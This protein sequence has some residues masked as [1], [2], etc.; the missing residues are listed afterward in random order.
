MTAEQRVR[1]L[2]FVDLFAGI[3]GMRLGFE[4]AGCVCVFSSEIDEYCQ[5]MYAL[6]FGERPFGDIKNIDAK[7]V[8]DHDIL[9]AGFP[10]Q[11]FSIMGNRLGLADL[12]G[13]LFFDIER[14]LKAKRPS[15]FLLENVKQLVGNDN[16]R[17]FKV[18][19]ER[20]G[21]LGY[22]VN[23]KILNALN[24]GL[25]QKRERV[26]IVGFQEN[27]SFQFPTRSREPTKSLSDILEKNVPKKYYVSEHI[28]KNRIEA[29]TSRF[30]LGIWH[31]NKAGHISSYPYSCA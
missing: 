31:E 27:Y 1:P 15:A 24:F 7:D 29:H 19:L 18:I 8:P 9:L 13:T 30:N 23:W 6:N 21:A 10:C 17:T 26:F 12:R 20:L 11:P 4:K 16:G 14:M 25:P 2:T 3:G 28:R 5:R 22:S